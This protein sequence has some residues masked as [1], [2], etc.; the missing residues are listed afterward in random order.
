MIQTTRIGL[1]MGCAAMLAVAACGGG[2]ESPADFCTRM[3]HMS[4]QFAGLQDNPSKTLIQQAADSASQAA[5]NA[6]DEIK[7]AVKTQ[8][9]AFA[10]WAK[11][12]NSAVLS[13]PAYTT[14]NDQINAWT[15]SNCKKGQ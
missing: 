3:S 8:A 12:G 14:A 6:P 7:D 15:S 2:G 13:T 10:Q 4:V 5:A 1:A 9:D 11:T